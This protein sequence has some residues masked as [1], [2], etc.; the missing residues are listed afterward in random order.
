MKQ[1][2]LDLRPLRVVLY[3]AVILSMLV[4]PAPGTVAVYEGV[5]VLNT[6]IV[7]VLAPIM[8]MLL[9]LDAIIAKVWHSQTEASEKAR[10][11][12]IFLIDMIGSL[13]FILVWVPYF[14]ALL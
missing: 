6:M 3:L 1:F 8:L 9:W 13:L 14:T 7:P 4:K 5:E 2:L 10:Y 12:K 11:W